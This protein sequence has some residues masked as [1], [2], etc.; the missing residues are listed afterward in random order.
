MG[1][2]CVR[3]DSLPPGGGSDIG[4]SFVQRKGCA[5]MAFIL[6]KFAGAIAAAIISI[7]LPTLGRDKKESSTLEVIKLLL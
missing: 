4:G 5:L 6:K 3:A 2:A 7:G 1:G